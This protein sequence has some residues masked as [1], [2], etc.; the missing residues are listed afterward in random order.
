MQR[1]A[2][3]E[4]HAPE[5][6]LPPEAEH[7]DHREVG[8]EAVHGGPH[9]HPPP[10]LLPRGR[11][12]PRP[13]E[14]GPHGPRGAVVGPVRL[15]E[16][17][18]G[19]DLLGLERRRRGRLP[20]GLRRPGEARRGGEVGE[21]VDVEAVRLAEA[22]EPRQ[23][24]RPAEDEQVEQEHHQPEHVPAP[25]PRPRRRP[26]PHPRRPSHRRRRRRPRG[27]GARVRALPLR[28]RHRSP[29]RPAGDQQQR[30]PHRTAP[31][32]GISRERIAGRRPEAEGM[33]WRRRRGW[34]GGV[35][36]RQ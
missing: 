24:E 28:R 14:G 21:A 12:Q 6:V 11:R 32:R 2:D 27:A 30:G 34:G 23:R 1:S 25:P 36:A 9:D 10:V 18:L 22:V 31:E 16:L 4:R 29:P 8:G 35:T 20:S 13:R 5:E 7:A 3:G 17:G 15:R 26:H 19:G 33:T